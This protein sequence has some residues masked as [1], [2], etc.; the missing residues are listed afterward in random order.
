MV[1][2]WEE[3]KFGPE[4]YMQEIAIL[5]SRRDRLRERGWDKPL[6]WTGEYPSL[7]YR[8]AVQYSKGALFLAELRKFVGDEAFWAGVKLYTQT[9]AQKTV[10][11]QDFQRA[12]QKKTDR[13]LAPLFDEWV[14]G[15]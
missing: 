15:T 1:A 3:H 10:V 14:Y 6:T 9:Y 11:S 2:A 7:G 4:A 5:R 8:R 13:D 12:M